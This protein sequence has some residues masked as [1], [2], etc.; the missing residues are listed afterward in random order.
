[1]TPPTFA[2]LR[3]KSQGSGKVKEREVGPSPLRLQVSDTDTPHT[4]AW[5]AKYTVHGAAAAHFKVV[6]DAET[7]DG[8]LT[9]VK[10]RAAPLQVAETPG[11]LALGVIYEVHA[12]LSDCSPLNT[13]RQSL[14]CSFSRMMDQRGNKDIFFNFYI[15]Q[16][17]TL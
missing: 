1:M 4:P 2:L 8:T 14:C 17:H 13:Q 15:F 9:V 7:N 12:H 6:T 16:R 11:S 5:R 3:L 10:V